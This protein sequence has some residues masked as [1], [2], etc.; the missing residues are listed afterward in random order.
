MVSMSSGT[1]KNE[2]AGRTYVPPHTTTK[3]TDK[4]YDS[5]M[6]KMYADRLG[7]FNTHTKP[8]IDQISQ[9][10]NSTEAYDRSRLDAST[11]G[12]KV[13]TTYQNNRNYSMD[14]DLPSMARL[15][16]RRRSMATGVAQT[17]MITNGGMM[18]RSNRMAARNQLMGISEQLKDTG[19][20]SMSQALQQKQQRDDAYRAAKGGFMSQVGALAGAGIGFMAG[21]PMGA[22]AGAG[23]GGGIGGAI[24][25]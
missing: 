1:N 24:G 3:V 8:L 5:I 7:D 13:N 18:A 15:S 2:L 4:N 20:A 9:E 21:G 14:G 11:L 12:D 22:A 19:S 23:I 10:A 25:G 16:S 17:A 6:A